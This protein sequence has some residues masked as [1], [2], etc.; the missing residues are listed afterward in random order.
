MEIPRYEAKEVRGRF[1]ARRLQFALSERVRAGIRSV[2]GEELTAEEAV[3]RIVADVAAGG[4]QA[5]DE[6]SLKLDRHATYE[7]PK[8]EW[9][10]AYD[11]LSTELREALGIARERLEKFHRKEPKG[12]FLAATSSGMLAQIVRPIRRVGAYVPGGSAPLLSTV[13]HTVVLARVAGVQ[14]VIVA[15][16]PPVHP[17]VMAAAWAAGADRLFAMGGAQAVAAL[18]YGTEQVPRVDKIVGPGNLF[19][20]LAKKEVYGVVGIDGLAGPTETLIVADAG[21]DP[22][23]VAADLLAQA[24]HDPAAEPWLLSPDPGL[25]DA[26]AAELERQLATLPRAEIARAAL[27]NGGLVRVRDLASALE[28]ADLYAPEHLCLSV[29]RPT[30]WLGYVN[31]AG[32]VFLGE[33]SGEAI[34]DYLA[35]PSHVMPTSGSARWTGAL[36]VR[37]F[38]KIVP[39]VA[40]SAAAAAE[41]SALGARL[42]REEELEAHARSLEQRTPTS[43]A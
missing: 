5:L 37:D 36:A 19:V 38:L 7:V 15:T 4:Q 30:D 9:R 23:T 10:E 17:G 29:E 35:G 41:L 39:V 34:G 8:R 11:D 22:A 16:P 28:L 25:L 20:T 26:V 32:G 43:D 13:L 31:N 21:A 40:L 12:G 33:H 1:A 27:Q 2:F 42:A 14:E 24:E 3:R 18:A 6:W